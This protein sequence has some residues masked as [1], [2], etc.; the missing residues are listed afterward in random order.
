MSSKSARSLERFVEAQAPV[1]GHVCAELRAGGKQAH[2]MW[3]IFP[4]L[5]S[6][7]RSSTAKFY[8]L[9]DVGDARAYLTHPVLGSRLRSC[10]DLVLAMEGKTAHEAFGSPDD[11]KLQS[12]MTLF[13][14]AAHPDSPRFAEVLD[15]FY[16]GKRDLQ[17]LSLLG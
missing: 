14:V 6:L 3:F 17:T 16:A 13:E 9:H 7:G 10:V 5:A 12:C 11:L 8:G 1:F 4:Q 2:W 15:W